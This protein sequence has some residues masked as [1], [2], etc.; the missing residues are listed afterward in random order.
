MSSAP[1]PPPRQLI[2]GRRLEVEGQL[3]H[4]SVAVCIVLQ[5]VL[6]QVGRGSGRVWDDAGPDQSKE[7][8]VDGQTA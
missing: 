4:R 8:G 7:G 5:Q 1:P 3:L 2:D 6:G